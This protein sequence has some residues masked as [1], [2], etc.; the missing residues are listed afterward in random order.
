MVQGLVVPHRLHEL[1]FLRQFAAPGSEGRKGLGAIAGAELAASLLAMHTFRG[2]GV[3]KEVVDGEF[4]E[5]LFWNELLSFEGDPPDP[6]VGVVASFVAEV[7]FTVLDDW[8]VPIS[9]VKGTIGAHLD[10]DGPKGP[11]GGAQK[12]IDPGRDVST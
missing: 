12:V 7:D 11:V 6:S 9:N 8:I 5:V 1:V 10:I 3:G 4:G 2:Y